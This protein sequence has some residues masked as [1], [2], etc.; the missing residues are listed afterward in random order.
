MAAEPRIGG[1]RQ[2][3][4]RELVGGDYTFALVV[5]EN[6]QSFGVP[7]GYRGGRTLVGTVADTDVSV[8]VRLPPSRNAE[9][10]GL[11]RGD[12]IRVSGTVVEWQKLD[13]RPLVE[14]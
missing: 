1:S 8:E 3:R 5:R 4:I 12:R 9:T 6:R 13:G 14:A 7:V 2:D 10:R 11:S